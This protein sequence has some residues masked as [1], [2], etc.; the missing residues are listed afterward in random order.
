[1]MDSMRGLLSGSHGQD[2]GGIDAPVAVGV[3]ERRMQVRAYNH[4][5]SL[6]SD[7]AY[8]SVEDLDLG[9]V[10]DFG[11]HSVRSEEHT[12]ELQSLM[13]NSYAVFCLKTQKN[14]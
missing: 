14:K 13:R 6:L 1:M 4:W 2:D 11:P 8:P 5:A 9:H 3:D 12:S 10:G 7:R